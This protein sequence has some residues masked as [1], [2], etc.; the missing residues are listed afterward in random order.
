MRNR[1]PR[2]PMAPMMPIQP[3]V[4]PITDESIRKAMECW[5]GEHRPSEQG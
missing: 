1:K 2:M 4:K 3:Y 5:A